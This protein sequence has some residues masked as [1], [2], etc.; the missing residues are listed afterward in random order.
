[1]ACDGKRCRLLCTVIRLGKCNRIMT[2]TSF[3]Q[4][5]SDLNRPTL[6]HITIRRKFHNFKF[7]GLGFSVTVISMSSIDDPLHDTPRANRLAAIARI[8]AC[9]HPTVQQSS[10]QKVSDNLGGQIEV[11]ARSTPHRQRF[12]LNRSEHAPWISMVT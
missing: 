7:L 11:L 1:M 3:Y 12:Q 2:I 8:S 4:Q 6:T 5:D 9:A 10:Y